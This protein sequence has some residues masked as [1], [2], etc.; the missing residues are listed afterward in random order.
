MLPKMWG[1]ATDVLGSRVLS[2]SVMLG[3]VEVREGTDF[4]TAGRVAGGNGPCE[5]ALSE[6]RCSGSHN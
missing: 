1:L 6:A 4:P 2:L 3:D 5:A